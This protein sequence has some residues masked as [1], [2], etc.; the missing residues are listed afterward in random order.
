MKIG[1]KRTLWILAS[2]AIITPLGFYSKFYNGPAQHWVNNSLS[3][4]FYVIFWCLVGFLFFQKTSP[5]K[6]AAIVLLITCLLEFVQLLDHPL[7]QAARSCSFGRALLGT[8]FV[9]SDF[10]YYFAASGIGWLWITVLKKRAKGTP[11]R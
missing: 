6:I 4:V 3:G 10:P 11:R 1:G 9:W 7:L 2:L 5:W 8:S